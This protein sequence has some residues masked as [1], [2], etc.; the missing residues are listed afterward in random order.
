MRYKI[1]LVLAL[2]FPLFLAGCFAGGGGGGNSVGGTD[3]DGTWKATYVDPNVKD[4]SPS[5]GET[6]YCSQPPV[7]IVIVN[8]IGTARQDRTC[9]AY[10]T[11]TTTAVGLPH[12]TYYQ[13]GVATLPGNIFNATVNGVA[14]TGK[15]ISPAGCSAPSATG[16]LSIN[17]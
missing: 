14:L 8:G 10:T 3:Y 6:M 4:P 16:G 12:I 15:C 9:Q 13:I 2:I 11:G 17:R 7:D 1:T 5:T